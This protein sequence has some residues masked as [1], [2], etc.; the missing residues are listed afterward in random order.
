MRKLIRATFVVGAIAFGGSSAC[1]INER[2]VVQRAPAAPP[3]AARQQGADHPAYLHALSDLRNARWNI[4]R[5]GGDPQMRWDEREAVGAIDQAINEIKQAAI[6]D[7]K[8]LD[9][10][11][12]VDAREPRAGRLHRA[13]AALRTARADVEKDEDN[14]YARGLRTRAIR[15]I[16][17]ALRFADQ[18]VAEVDRGA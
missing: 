17:E 4:Q 9:D 18:G 8:D 15:H 6:D 13:V 16:D 10:H 12:P 5:R 14:A 3:P 7:G 1:T 2:T 11:A